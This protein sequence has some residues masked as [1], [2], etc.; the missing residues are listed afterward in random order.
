MVMK[1]A[2]K[3]RDGLFGFAL[4]VMPDGGEGSNQRMIRLD[5]CALLEFEQRVCITTLIHKDARAVVTDDH[6]LVRIQAQHPFE[7]AQRLIILSVEPI[8]VRAD[9]MH[10]DIV[11]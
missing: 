5:G 4:P 6:T 7:T 3:D 11:R 2:F 9:E 1:H 10:A 8:K